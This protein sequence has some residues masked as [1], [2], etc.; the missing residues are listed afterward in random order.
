MP[1]MSN[2][3]G[4]KF[5]WLR[6]F[7]GLDHQVTRA[8]TAPPQAAAARRAQPTLAVSQRPREIELYVRDRGPGFNLEAKG[9]SSGL[10]LVAVLAERL[11]GTFTVERRSGAR[12]TLRFPDQ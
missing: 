2:W 5:C 7:A 6:A 4:W 11:N 9:H 3:P 8:E 12:C 1:W 10:G